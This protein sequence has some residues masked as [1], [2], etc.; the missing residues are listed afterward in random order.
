[1]IFLKHLRAC[2]ENARPMR[3]FTAPC[4][5]SDPGQHGQLSKALVRGLDQANSSGA[6]CMQNGALAKFLLAMICNSAR[7]NCIG[8]SE[9]ADHA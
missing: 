3:W 5:T 1:M 4:C 6:S 7:A 9:H 2:R 8:V